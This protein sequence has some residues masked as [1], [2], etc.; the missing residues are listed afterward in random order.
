MIG[1][2]HHH[3]FSLLL[4]SGMICAHEMTKFCEKFGEFVPSTSHKPIRRVLGMACPGQ[5]L[6]VLAHL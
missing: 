5:P 6:S 3:V 4:S 1:F 2:L